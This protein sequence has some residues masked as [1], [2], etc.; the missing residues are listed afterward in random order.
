[1]Q[2]KL[3]IRINIIE[4]LSD[5]FAEKLNESL[6]KEGIEL[7][8]MKL[9]IQ[10]ILIDLSKMIVIFSIAVVFN[11]LKE[12]AFLFFIFAV[13]RKNAFGVHARNSLVCTV[14]STFLFVFGA[15]A[16]SYIVFNNAEIMLLFSIMNVLIYKYAPADTENR[17]LLGRKFRDKLK[18][19][20]V[21]TGIFLMLLALIFKSPLIKTLITLAYSYEVISILP[22][23][24][25]IL[26]RRCKNYEQY[27]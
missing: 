21:I 13:A 4:A 23:T 17:P 2:N 10:I 14:S 9:G 16:S 25:K 22:I 24:Y 11:L 15:Y 19:N 20:A 18:K 8:K 7:V 26:K 3:K 1:M 5:M 6:Q 27:E 12:T